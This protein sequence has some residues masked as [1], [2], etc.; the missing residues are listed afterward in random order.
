[1][2]LPACIGPIA[3]VELTENRAGQQ[4]TCE[5]I[6]QGVHVSWLVVASLGTVTEIATCR[7]PNQPCSSTKE[8]AGTR[9]STTSTLTIVGNTTRLRSLQANRFVCR[10]STGSDATCLVDIVCEY[11]QLCVC[12]CVLLSIH[13]QHLK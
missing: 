3:A 12:V 10:P 4:I 2:S 6:A 1:M 11:C 8:V 13:R 7:G 9:D 5:N